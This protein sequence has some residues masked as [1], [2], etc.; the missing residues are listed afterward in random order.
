MNTIAPLRRTATPLGSQV[1]LLLATA[2]R[3]MVGLLMTALLGRG[4][5]AREFGFYGLVSTVFTFA[6][7]LTDMGSGNV[8]LR[9]I[10]RAPGAERTSI[11]RLLGLRLALSAAAA[12]AC[13]VLASVQD[14]LTHRV[15]LLA[16]A[17]VLIFFFV[18][19]V[20][21]VFQ[22]RQAQIAPSL[23]SVAA[24]VGAL[25]L[26]AMFLR[27]GGPG[28][29]AS[30]VVILREA[31]ILVGVWWL[32]TALLG[33]VPRPRPAHVAV[34]GFLGPAI[35]VA[36]ATTGYHF[37]FQGGV[38]FVQTMRPAAE[39]GA[40]TAALRPLNPI[41]LLPWIIMLP[42]TPMLSWLAAYDPTGFQNQSRGLLDEAIG[43]GAVAAVVC[44]RL[45]EPILRFLFAEAFVTGAQ[46]AVAALGWLGL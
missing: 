37:L 8:A 36:L 40:F 45:A 21:V 46:S 22:N 34:G 16:A 25:G 3:M 2:A 14:N 26:A 4:L 32:G 35:I 29:A 30:V 42:V 31:V 24:Q 23:L 13:V 39:L 11:E 6:H 1:V 20:G 44:L 5:T 41:L 18:G 9:E 27:L 12:C 17:A 15:A 33:Y 28:E 38:F 19:G 7:D 10:A 43:L